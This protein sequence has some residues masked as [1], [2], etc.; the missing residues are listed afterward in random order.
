MTSYFFH[1]LPKISLCIL[2]FAPVAFAGSHTVTMKS[3]S[4]EPKVLE[5]KTGDTVEWI[6]KSYT[7]HSATS[8]A[9]EKSSSKFDTGDIHPQKTSKKIVFKEIGT[10]L[11]HCSVHGKTMSGKINVTK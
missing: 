2:L 9:D 5:V 11:Y 3:I 7:D 4:Y 1:I 10:F 8:A 6:N